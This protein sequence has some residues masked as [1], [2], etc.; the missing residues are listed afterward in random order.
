MKTK[1]WIIGW[2]IIV[3][4]GLAAIGF[5]VYRID[6][7]FHYHKPNIKSYFYELNNQRSQ[8]DGISKHFEYDALITGTSMTE[9]FKT[10]ELDEIFGVNS[11]KV[12]YAGGSYKEINDNLK[13]ALKYHPDLRL[14]VRGLDMEMF[15]SDPDMMRTDLGEYPTYLYDENPFN[16]VKYL[17]NKDVIF[18]RAYTMTLANDTDDFKP[19]ITSFDDYSSWH[20][21][22]TFG[23]HTVAPDGIFFDGAGEAVH[24]TDE[25]K[26]IIR[27]NITQNV[28]FLADAYPDVEFYYFFTPYSILWYKDLLTSGTIYQQVEAER[29]IIELILACDNIK[30]F[31]FNSDQSIIANLNHYKDY[32]HYA[33]WINSY[34]LRCMYEDKYRLTKDNYEEYIDKELALFIDYDYLS[35]NEQTDYETDFYM[36]ALINEKIWGVKPV[37]VL[38]EYMDSVILMN[39]EIIDG[40]YE[41]GSGIRCVG[42]L[43]REQGREDNLADDIQGGN[44]IGAEIEIESIG[45]HDFLIFYGKKVV[46]HG[47]PMVFVVND[48]GEK[49]GEFSMNYHNIDTE[50]HPYGIDLSNVEGGIRIYFN[51]GYIDNTGSMESEFI[52]SGIRLY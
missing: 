43:Q 2:F 12:C 45:R 26:E 27:V 5:F 18:D 38:S 33:Q 48:N 34:I 10:S 24:L 15:F 22:Y 37:D 36:A 4:I 39:A 51:G 52:F 31:S 3:S 42:S 47:Q 41:N 44:Y 19:G 7:Y 1:G 14:V 11:V 16:D 30:L 40:Q 20:E 8:N 49:M 9:N 28:T 32:H 46:D 17:F 6:P 23:V 21:Y 35:L 25:Q 29:Y 13:V 50:W